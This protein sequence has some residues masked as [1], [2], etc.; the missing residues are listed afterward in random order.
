MFSPFLS[1]KKNQPIKLA[2]ILFLSSYKFHTSSVHR[3]RKR[4]NERRTEGQEFRE[5]RSPNKV[6]VTDTILREG[7]RGEGRRESLSLSVPRE[8]RTEPCSST[9]GDLLSRKLAAV[10]AR[11]PA[12][13]LKL[14]FNYHGITEGQ[15]R[16]TGRARH[17]I[18]RVWPKF[19]K[20]RAR[21]RETRSTTW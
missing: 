10:F 5:S 17:Q 20:G 7:R 15:W 19:W 11:L 8:A 4:D 18:P 12:V 6:S 9:R 3:G 2:R 21:V 13:T 1:E 14:L 16:E